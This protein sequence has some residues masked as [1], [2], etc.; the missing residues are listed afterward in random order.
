MTNL[1]Y[2]KLSTRL[3]A[4]WFF[5]SLAA[6]ALRVF[7]TAPGRPPL[8]LG[9]AAL[10]PIVVFL[11]W[12]ASSTR[13]REFAL[14]LNPRKLTLVHTWRI[15]GF[16][17][18]VLYAYGILPGMFAFPA[19]IGDIAIGATAP[20]VAMKFAVPDRRKTFILWQLLGISDLVIAVFLGSTAALFN[21]SGIAT[22]A[23]N[24]L[25]MSLIPTFLVPLLLILHVIS[26]AQA[27]RWHAQPY[28]HIG[29]QLPFSAA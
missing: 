26:I 4:V 25:P 24:V 18:L 20:W 12:F 22:S 10:A 16:V 14:N 29:N 13:F 9:I 7:R 2:G 23:M 5:F 28:S 17:F 8:L 3:I 6:S 15:G 21:P 27:R 11:L 19:G 1:N